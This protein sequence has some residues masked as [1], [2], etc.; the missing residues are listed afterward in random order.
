MESVYFIQDAVNSLLTLHF[1]RC[2]RRLS[3]EESHTL[4]DLLSN[5]FFKQTSIRYELLPPV[6]EV[7]ITTT[8]FEQTT[9]VRNAILAKVKLLPEG[10]WLPVVFQTEQQ[11]YKFTYNRVRNKSGEME[12]KKR[13]QIVF[14][15]G[16]NGG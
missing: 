14:V 8:R 12:Y 9:K 2:G 7:P 6:V 16:Q 3:V 13:K 15:R 1:E 11:A 4:S 5:F 10:C